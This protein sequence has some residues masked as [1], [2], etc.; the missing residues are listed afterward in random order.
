MDIDEILLDAEERMIKCVADYELHLK[1]VRSGQASIEMVDHVHVDIPAYGGVVPLKSVA[2][3]P[4]M[5]VLFP[6]PVVPL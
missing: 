4:S 1:G 5:R 6:H 3:V 2:L